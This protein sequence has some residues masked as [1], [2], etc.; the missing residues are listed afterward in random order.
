M[1][2]CLLLN[3]FYLNLVL[4]SYSY[5]RYVYLHFWDIPGGPVAKTLHFQWRG[6]G[7]EPWLG[8]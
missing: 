5:F 7:V 3:L 4:F 2:H 8:E 1:I 6:Y